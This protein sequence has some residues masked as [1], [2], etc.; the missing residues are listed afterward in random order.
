[1]PIISKLPSRLKCVTQQ[2]L[3]RGTNWD[4]NTAE[5]LV[6]WFD[7]ESEKMLNSVCEACYG[8]MYQTHWGIIWSCQTEK[9]YEIGMT[10]IK[11]KSE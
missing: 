1:M 3:N 5:V 11:V 6:A 4:F 9:E 8:A 2:F 10:Y 7:G